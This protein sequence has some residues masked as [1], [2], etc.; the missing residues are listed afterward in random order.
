MFIN[1]SAPQS[2][3]HSR[4]SSPVKPLGNGLNFLRFGSP[5]TTLIHIPRHIAVLKSTS[6]NDLSKGGLDLKDLINYKATKHPKPKS[7]LSEEILSEINSLKFPIK[8]FNQ[9]SRHKR[10]FSLSSSEATDHDLMRVSLEKALRSE[11]RLPAVPKAKLLVEQDSAPEIQRTTGYQGLRIT[12]NQ[13]PTKVVQSFFK[14][15]KTGNVLDVRSLL[16]GHRGLVTAVDSVGNTGLHWAAKRGDLVLAETLVKTGFDVNAV[17]IANRTPLYL[18][19]RMDK[20]KVVQYLLAVGADPAICSINSV[21]P[22]QASKDSSAS[23]YFLQTIPACLPSTSTSL[24]KTHRTA[25]F[26]S[27]P[28]TPSRSDS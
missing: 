20:A 1:K 8:S 22:L 16:I 11:A 23:R 15:V 26:A 24:P 17:D 7:Y 28:S 12:C 10:Y 4:K 19:A 9:V 18:A 3:G 13:L 5:T 6:R 25:A 21:S 14:A 27:Q 2:P